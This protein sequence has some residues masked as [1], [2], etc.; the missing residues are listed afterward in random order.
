MTPSRWTEERVAALRL[1]WRAGLSASQV[2]RR[3]GG[4][5]TRCAVLGKLHRLGVGRR[6][7]ASAPEAGRSAP[8]S[9]VT[10]APKPRP[11]KRRPPKPQRRIV[12][13]RRTPPTEAA[14]LASV[15]SVGAH[16]CRWPIGD[17][18]DEAFSLC[19]R[20]ARRG[21]YCADHGARAYRGHAEAGT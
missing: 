10:A 6:A 1:L 20:P 17:P 9:G 18:K 12:I 13:P 7:R 5:V 8:V 4:G 19:G 2:A 16:A 11:A 15:L 3:L 14:G 21:A